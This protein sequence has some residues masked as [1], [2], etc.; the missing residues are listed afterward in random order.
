MG[1]K[2]LP[3]RDYM[4]DTYSWNIRVQKSL[5]KDFLERYHR[6]RVRRKSLGERGYFINRV[7]SEL[8]NEYIKEVDDNE[9]ENNKRQ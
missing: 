8:L 1:R 5:L 2:K 3:D 7:I 9:K 6:E 4:N